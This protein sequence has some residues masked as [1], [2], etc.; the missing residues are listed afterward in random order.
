M[1]SKTAARASARVRNLASWTH[2][3]LSEAN[4]LSMGALSR[5]LP[6]RLIDCWI[7]CRSSTARYG[8]AAYCPGSSGRR[9]T[10]REEVAMTV[11]KRRSD[12]SGRGALPSPG[13]PSVARREDRQRFWVLIAA[14]CSSEGAA[15]GAGVSPAVGARWFRRAGGMPP[16]QLAPSSKSLSGRSLSFAERE[17]I[18]IW[19][20]QRQGV[21]ETARRLERA[22]STISR[23]LRRNAATR[24]GGL[25]YR[26]TTAQWH[27]DRSARRPKSAK[28]AINEPLRRY[29]QDRLA[30]VIITP[31]GAA[32][33]GPVV[34]WKGRRHGRRQD[35]RWA[36][37][38]SPE[39]IAR[40]LRLDFPDDET[41]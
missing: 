27:A 26:A 5:Q 22:P 29:V 28:L 24:S 32:V 41:M 23:E 20:A 36:T 40:R 38:W 7:P 14:G 2:S 4:K 30:G 8:P 21:R 35:R 12:R 3:V 1:Y 18:P 9:N 19:P 13:R 33:R 34:P 11:R 17:E 16:S 31:N 15:V 25:D 37:A 39:Q 10:L 6:R